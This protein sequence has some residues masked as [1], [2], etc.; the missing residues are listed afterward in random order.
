MD[1]AFDPSG[2]M[3]THMNEL[4]MSLRRRICLVRISPASNTGDAMVCL[5]TS[6]NFVINQRDVVS[7]PEEGV[8]ILLAS[9]RTDHENFYKVYTDSMRV[10]GKA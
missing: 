7:L 10:A 8:A 9:A 4:D 2:A 5:H 3:A 6:S 1:D